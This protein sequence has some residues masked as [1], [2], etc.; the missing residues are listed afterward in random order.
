M[1]SVLSSCKYL[2]NIITS[3]MLIIMKSHENFYI[4]LMDKIKLMSRR[5]SE[6]KKYIVTS[7]RIF[8]CFKKM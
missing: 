1:L 4:N 8:I 3:E 7:T 2:M 6:K 5:E